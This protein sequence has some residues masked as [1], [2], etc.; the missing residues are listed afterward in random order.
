MLH[1][2]LAFLA[3]QGQPSRP[4]ILVLGTYHMANPGRD[5]HNMKAD[6]VLAPKRQGEVAALMQVFEKF[7]PTK[8]AIEAEVGSKKVTQQYADYLAG[9]YTLTA[10]EVDQIGYRLAKDLGHQTI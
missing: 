9:K 3:L 1:L 7:R 2:A 4:E 6:D 5:V 8:V 10:N